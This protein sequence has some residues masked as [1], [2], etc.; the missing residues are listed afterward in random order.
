MSES[1]HDSLVSK[2][3]VSDVIPPP[4]DRPRGPC[5]DSGVTPWPMS[6]AKLIRRPDSTMLGT[7]TRFGRRRE[8]IPVSVE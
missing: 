3:P 8:P 1:D 2:T 4:A 5:D 6:L 7:A